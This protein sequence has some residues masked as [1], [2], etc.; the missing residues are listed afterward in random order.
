MADSVI[1]RG[2]NQPFGTFPRDRLDADARGLR[3][4]NLGY[5]HFVAEE[6]DDL[7]GFGRVSRPFDARIDVLGVFT[8]DYDVE[9]LGMPYRAWHSRE[10]ADR[11][12]TNVE[13]EELAQ[14]HIERSNSPADRRGQRTLDADQ[15]LL[16][17]ID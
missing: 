2:A 9:F 17:R 15:K 4:T 14:S 3:K 12:Q 13:I 5:A 8:E 1:E 10:I 16:E 11:T 6:F 7:F